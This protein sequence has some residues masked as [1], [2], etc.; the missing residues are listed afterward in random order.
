MLKSIKLQCFRQHLDRAF[1][2]GPGLNAI[3][4]ENEAGKTTVLEAFFYFCFGARALRESIDDIVTYHQPVS[5]LRVDCE[6]EHL[7]V[8]YSGYRGK[9][10]AEL[11]FGREKITGQNEVTAFFEKLF[12]ADAKLAGKLMFASQKSLAESLKEGPTA[13]GK[14]IEELANFDLIDRVAETIAARRQTGK[15]DGVEARI[16][17]LKEQEAQGQ[18][19]EDLAPL[20]AEVETA[21]EMVIGAGMELDVL[22]QRRA[23]QDV[24]LARQIIASEAALARSIEKTTFDIDAIDR[25]LG[26]PAV[27]A[28]PEGSIEKARAAVEAGKQQARAAKLSSE[29]LGIET[30]GLWDQDM[31]SLEAEVA[32]TQSKVQVETK[33]HANISQAMATLEREHAEGVRASDVRVAQL[34]GRLIKE[35][36]CALCQKDLS[37]VPEVARTNSDLQRQ[38]DEVKLAAVQAG[39]EMR[40]RHTQ[41]GAEL[42]AAQLELDTQLEYLA[43]LNDV[44]RTNGQVEQLYARAADFI[45]VDRSVVP[46]QWKWIGP[47]LAHVPADLANQLAHLETLQREADADVARRQEK[48]AQRN[49]LVLE[50]R[51][52]I[53]ARGELQLKDAQETLEQA[54]Q[55]DQ[56]VKDKCLELGDYRAKLQRLQSTLTT[57]EALAAQQQRQLELTRTQLAAAEAELAQM[58][59]YNLLIKKVRA[60]R[61]VITN[62]L[63]NIV[64]GGVSKHFSEVRG[65]ESRITRADG[66]FK[67]NGWPVSG[68]SGSAEDMLGLAMRITLTRTFLPGI[69]MLQLDEPAAACSDAR[70]TRML[71]M[72]STLGFGQTIVVS[73]SDLTD[74]VADRIITV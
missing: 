58:Q 33:V 62:K 39:N 63:W 5:R 19:F 50:R 21:G 66:T 42:D 53:A 15:T 37:D 14:M 51:D 55:L 1:E 35:T 54:G 28:P 26:R 38:I 34:E 60:A 40:I 20:R 27:L 72:L 59:K 46:G 12:G 68:L 71:G 6:I 16:A 4:G 29:L 44:I 23:E 18:M 24:D 30:I 43:Q 65:Q 64:L 74:A 48:E 13:A 47:E 41:L 10:G 17:Q 67:C 8:V 56:Q 11:N 36:T 70:E 3:R 52:A 61:P 45:E 73:H 69:D 57:K 49:K 25:E 31:A 2:F 9:S 7:G 22:Q 32:L